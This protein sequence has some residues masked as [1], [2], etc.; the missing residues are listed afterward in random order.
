M[1]ARVRM[2]P[3]PPDG[4][5]FFPALPLEELIADVGSRR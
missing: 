2:P 3:R 4:A 5:G 1:S